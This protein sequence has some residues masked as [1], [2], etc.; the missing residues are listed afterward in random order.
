MV[1]VQSDLIAMLSA[2]PTLKQLSNLKVSRSMPTFTSLQ[3]TI[4]PTL[5]A[6][7]MLLSLI[8]IVALL[9]LKELPTLAVSR[10]MPT[11]TSLQPTPSPTLLVFLMLLSSSAPTVLPMSV[12]DRIQSTPTVM[13]FPSPTLKQLSTVKVSRS[14]PTFTSRQPTPS[15]THRAVI[16]KASTSDMSRTL[17]LDRYFRYSEVHSRYS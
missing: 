11:F 9:T 8:V 3:P 7:L 6:F 16:I 15:P 12:F 2:S 13:S 17:R 4:S 14:M 10:S 5:L 1:P